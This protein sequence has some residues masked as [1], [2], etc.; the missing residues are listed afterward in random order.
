[1]L[2][3][4]E[5]IET[6]DHIIVAFSGGKD[7]L[8]CFLH[9]LELGVPK[10]KIE[11]W[12]HLVDG[13]EGSTLM[14]W[15]C[16]EDYCRQVAFAFE[17]PI[18]YSWK[19]GGFEREMLRHETK[20][21]PMSYETPEGVRSSGGVRGNPGV[22]EMFPQVSADLAIRWCSAYLK[23]NVCSAAIAN[24]SR[25]TGKRTLLITGERAEESSARAKYKEGELHRT[26]GQKRFVLQWRPV[27]Q[28]KRQQVWD[29]IG[30]YRVNPHPAYRLGWGRVSCMKCIFGSVNQWASVKQ[31]D[32]DGFKRI[33]DYEMKFGKTINRTKS[34][35]AQAYNGHAYTMIYDDRKAALSHSFDEPV[36]LDNWAFPAGAF[37]ENNGPT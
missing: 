32:P 34:V 6:F 37:G 31:L 36:F 14:D 29:L 8:A 11:L 2:T 16:T 33:F 25:F 18:Y 13:R 24:Q 23:V 21:A 35:D 12:H 28:W 26:S 5:D 22:R 19:Q 10:A 20:T 15:P 1:M 9:L 17:V 7:S 3:I 4:L 27:I 30:K